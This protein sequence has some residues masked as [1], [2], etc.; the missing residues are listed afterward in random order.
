M[1]RSRP[2]RSRS[3]PA[4]STPLRTPGLDPDVPIF[5]HVDLG[6]E[7]E[8][9]LLGDLE[10]GLEELAVAGAAGLVAGDDDLDRVPVAVLV[11]LER[12]VRAGPGIVADLEL[13]RE[14]LVAQVEA[15]IRI[16]R[17]AEFQPE[18]EVAVIR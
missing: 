12:L 6:L 15:A 3:R 10:G 17:G 4:P 5:N 13:V 16:P 7:R 14:D 8:G 9:A 1:R 2:T 18:G 11:I